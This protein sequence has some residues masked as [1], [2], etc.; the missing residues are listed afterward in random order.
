[1]FELGLYSNRYSNI[2]FLFENYTRFVTSNFSMFFIFCLFVIFCMISADVTV[3]ITT[4]A[5]YPVKIIP[6][7]LTVTFSNDVAS[8]DDNDI[9]VTNG[10]LNNL[11]YISN[12][13]YTIDFYPLKSTESS[14]VYIEAGAGE[15]LDGSLSLQSNTLTITYDTLFTELHLTPISDTFLF[16]YDCFYMPKLMFNRVLMIR[17]KGEGLLIGL[18]PVKGMSDKMYIVNITTET[19]EIYK[20]ENGVKTVI[21]GYLLSPVTMTTTRMQRMQI[22]DSILGQ[23]SLDNLD[24]LTQSIMLLD[25]KPISFNYFS[26]LAPTN[27]NGKVDITVEDFTKDDQQFSVSVSGDYYPETAPFSVTIKFSRA[28]KNSMLYTGFNISYACSL[29]SFKMPW[30][31]DTLYLELYPRFRGFCTVMS[32]KLF[33]TIDNQLAFF[34]VHVA[35]LRQNYIKNYNITFPMSIY[36]FKYSQWCSIDDNIL[37]LTFSVKC[38][39][40]TTIAFASNIL[41]LSYYE[42][43][44]G[45]NSDSSIKLRSCSIF[46]CDDIIT[47]P[48][49]NQVCSNNRDS[50]S[51]M[52]CYTYAKNDNLVISCGYG[53][54]FDNNTMILYVLKEEDVN[55]LNYFTFTSFNYPAFIADVS[56]ENY[57]IPDVIPTYNPP[58][59]LPPP[60]TSKPTTIHPPTTKP[61]LRPTSKPQPKPTGGGNVDDNGG[62]LYSSCFGF[63][64]LV[65]LCFI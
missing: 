6:V 40:D 18:S 3:T 57:D 50:L 15:T 25:P 53:V 32:A 29:K 11:G 62:L 65:V 19:S 1:M 4:S 47:I 23:I 33:W 61:T 12:S 49:S 22:T 41:F 30:P 45:A 52:W 43:V 51:E 16:W 28:A 13:T 2:F 64:I 42:I 21:S 36:M 8:F 27:I 39:D 55:A 9:R 48:T 20:L 7:C 46:S 34:F 60:I 14:S 56:I 58:K 63:V 38:V 24:S 10:M 35:D 31:W 44:F 59:T 26:F 5:T 54:E 17:A 37:A